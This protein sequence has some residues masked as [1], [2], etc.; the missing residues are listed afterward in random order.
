M[1]PA[2]WISLASL[3]VA[4]FIQ[5]LVFVFMLGR[6]FQDVASLKAAT[7]ERAIQGLAIARLEVQVGHISHKLDEMGTK[8][9]ER[10]GFLQ[11]P[12]AYVPRPRSRKPRASE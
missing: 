10:L 9:D 4:M 7:P 12:P 11:E 1:T 8:I 5:A 2:A 3:A 6:V